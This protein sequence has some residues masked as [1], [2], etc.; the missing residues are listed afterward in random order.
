MQVIQGCSR[1]RRATQTAPPPWSRSSQNQS[2]YRKP[3]GWRSLTTAAV[4]GALACLL[5]GCQQL[6]RLWPATS[7]ADAPAAR[8]LVLPVADILPSELRGG[9]GYT[10]ASR[11]PV[12]DHNAIFS[13]QTRYGTLSACGR[14]M[15]EL[16]CYETRCI[17]KAAKIRGVRQVLQGAVTRLDDT[18]EGAETLLTDPVGSIERTPKGL[19]RM[20]RGKLDRA[21]RRAGGPGQ[22]QLAVSLGCDP[23]TYNPIL[24]RML[25]EIEI[26]RLLGSLPVE[27]IPYTGI[28]R[29]T[30]DVMDEVAS[31]PPHEINERIEKELAAEGVAEDL[32]RDFCRC[33]HFTTV[34]RLLFMKQY[35]R[36]EGV[37]NR[38]A[39]L[40][41]AVEGN[42][43]TDA[44]GVIE[45][46]HALAA[47]HARRPIQGLAHRGLLLARPPAQRSA[48]LL[49][50][51][52]LPIPG[53]KKEPETPPGGRHGL[54]VAVL[55]EGSHLIYAPCDCIEKTTLLQEAV[56]A[57]RADFPSQPTTLVCS[58]RVLPE[59]RE[60]LETAGL[61]VQ[62]HARSGPDWGQTG[63]TLEA[64]TAPLESRLFRLPF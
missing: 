60:V 56:R 3:V 50:F 23:E 64:E 47:V 35:R 30:A 49:G 55:R 44:L 43:E 6:F 52:R 11:A 18:I 51:L 29:L 28:L 7:E 16:R 1:N 42:S 37:T 46:T 61:K 53:L 27:F 38:D 8:G 59:A 14:N 17:E 2:G 54:P 62:E 20:V 26:Q 31:T 34:E 36:L 12:V 48:G 22:R 21:S 9:P 5:A 32:R 41:F 13:I 45:M 58:G 40:A 4:L 24:R 39:L 25:K 57:Y 19:N 10:V 15:L 63:S 33:G